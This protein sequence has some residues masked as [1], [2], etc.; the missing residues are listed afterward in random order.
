MQQEQ[1]QKPRRKPHRLRPRP[2]EVIKALERTRGLY[3]P[4]AAILGVS[5][6]NLRAF[7]QNHS[8]VAYAVREITQGAV[9]VIEGNLMVRACTDTMSAKLV[10][11]AKAKDRGY[12][13]SSADEGG[14][15]GAGATVSFV[16]TP[17]QSGTFIEADAAMLERME[18][19]GARPMVRLDESPDDVREM[20]AARLKAAQAAEDAR[21]LE[22]KLKAKARAAK[23]K[24]SGGEA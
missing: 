3:G 18:E 5:R 23:V 10:L 21:Q 11:S 16:I 4:A 14:G 6:G 15:M 13:S 24:Q 19:S 2:D 7:V 1:P 12:G 20:F 22:F 8:R 9:D 17:I